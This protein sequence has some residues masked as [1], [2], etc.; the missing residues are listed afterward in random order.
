MKLLFQNTT[1]QNIISTTVVTS[2]LRGPTG[3][4]WE[5]SNNKI[6]FASF[7]IFQI[8]LSFS[9]SNFCYVFMWNFEYSSDDIRW[10][11]WTYSYLWLPLVWD[12][13]NAV[14]PM[15]NGTES[16]IAFSLWCHSLLRYCSISLQSLLNNMCQ[17]QAVNRRCVFVA[18]SL[19]SRHTRSNMTF[20]WRWL[21]CCTF[22]SSR[23]WPMFQVLTATIF[24]AIRAL[25]MEALNTIETTVNIY[26]TIWRSIPLCIPLEPIIIPYIN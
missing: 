13:R 4:S 1:L 15:W 21:G 24:R 11:K 2:L 10:T 20:P 5:P 18:W 14:T 25:M 22:W 26:W 3:I 7:T 16:I 23:D 12:E 9:T 17:L 6:L 8:S 19:I